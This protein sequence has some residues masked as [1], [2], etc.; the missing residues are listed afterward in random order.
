[1]IALLAALIAVPAL[2][3]IGAAISGRG[4][5]R[6]AWLLG[7]A[8]L[9]GSLV[10]FAWQ[11]P[12]ARL[13]GGGVLGLDGL[14]L[15]VLSVVSLVFLAV[16]AWSV[17]YLRR[18]SPRGGRWFAAC[19]LAFLAAASLVS[20]SRH[21]GLL[22]VGMEATT[23]SIAPL[24]FDRHDRRSLEAV[25]KYLMLSS[26]GIAFALLGTFLVATAQSNG[27]VPGRSLMIDDL[28]APGAGLDAAWL[29][30]GFVFLLVGYGTKMGIAP[31][32]TWKPDVYGEAPSF[33]GALMAGALT[34]VAFLGLARATQVAYSA[35]QEAFVR[36]LLLTAALVSLG[37]ATAFLLFGQNDIKRLLAYS[38]IEQMG[39][40]VLGLGLGGA[41]AF[42]AVLH[43]VNSGLSKAFAFLVVGNVVLATGSAL[44]DANRGLLRRLPLSGFLLLLGLIAITGAPPFGPFISEVTILRA[45]VEGGHPAMAIAVAVLLGL[46]FVGMARTILEVLYAPAGQPDAPTP[47]R[48]GPWLLVG[49]VGL[50]L[51]VTLLGV[52]LPGPLQGALADAARA[53]GGTVP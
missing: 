50:A 25:W 14:G 37:V 38:S 9:H 21:F 29:R 6:T 35:G 39:L 24:V 10:A 43:A 22:W 4:P 45:A 40:L 34:T 46:A 28:V 48:S 15:T 3:A 31:L 42:G 51:V 41:G 12:A 19:L 44:A 7:V 32:H 27:L 13:V 2:G 1:V 30:G 18:E 23:L 36:P 5:G 33:I 17:G 53:L 49:P 20:V 52:Y 16:A 8:G 47:A 26:V 11:S